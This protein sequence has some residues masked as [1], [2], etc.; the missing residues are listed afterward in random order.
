ML[1]MISLC[2]DDV[3]VPVVLPDIV[4]YLLGIAQLAHDLF[5]PLAVLFANDHLLSSLG[6]NPASA[7]FIKNSRKGLTDFEVALI[8]VDDKI[9][10]ILAPVLQ[11]GVAEVA[12]KL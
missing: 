4:L 2:D 5:L 1:Q 6:E 7:F 11:A 3:I 12:A 9:S 10:A 8:P